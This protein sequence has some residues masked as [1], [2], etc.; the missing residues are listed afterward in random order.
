VSKRVPTQFVVL[1]FDTEKHAWTEQ[2]IIASG[3]SSDAA[4]MAALDNRDLELG[5]G[6]LVVLV[7]QRSW[8]P[9]K[10]TV[11]TQLKIALER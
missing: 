5:D 11:K 8:R 7:P 10:V 4:L 9:T 2:S 3:S 1:T 6:D